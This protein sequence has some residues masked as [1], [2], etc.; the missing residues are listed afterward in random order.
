MIDIVD[1]LVMLLQLWVD[2][3]GF[4]SVL[5]LVGVRVEN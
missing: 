5:I 1:L 3:F 4:V 2:V